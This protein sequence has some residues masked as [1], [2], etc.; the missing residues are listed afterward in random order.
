MASGKQ[1]GEARFK[2]LMRPQR[3]V[4][5]AAALRGIGRAE[6][7]EQRQQSIVEAGGEG[8]RG[9]QAAQSCHKAWASC[10]L[11]KLLFDCP[12]T[13]LRSCCLQSP[14]PG[15]GPS[16]SSLL[17]WSSFQVTCL[18]RLSRLQAGAEAAAPSGKTVQE[19]LQN[20]Q[21]AIFLEIQHTRG[22]ITSFQVNHYNQQLRRLPRPRP[23][24]NHPP[25]TPSTVAHN[26]ITRKSFSLFFFWVCFVLGA[27]EALGVAYAA[28][29]TGLRL[30]R[31]IALQQQQ[32]QPSLQLTCEGSGKT[33]N[34][35]MGNGTAIAVF[36]PRIEACLSLLLPLGAY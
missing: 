2:F 30:L 9:R 15:P 32:R 10:N 33:G 20:S 34:W 27:W 24:P 11:G 13:S 21:P 25:P 23:R 17:S 4:T 12:H 3:V 5:L 22:A 26:R 8:R 14:A 35:E 19:K 29:G 1:N 6:G 7:R 36:G 28:C 31:L 18:S 16:H